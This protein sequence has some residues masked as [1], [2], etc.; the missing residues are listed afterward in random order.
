MAVWVLIFSFYASAMA[1]DNAIAVGS[2]PGFYTFEICEKA[3]KEVKR[4]FETTFK[5][6]SFACVPLGPERSWDT[7]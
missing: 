1:S 3:G 4:K 6:V 5:S 7:K 2:V